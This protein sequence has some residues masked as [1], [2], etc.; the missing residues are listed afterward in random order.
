MRI[1]E[2]K[3][4]ETVLEFGEPLLGA[5]EAPTVEEYRR[6][7][8]IVIT[9]WNAHGISMANPHGRTVYLKE[10]S[11]YRKRAAADGAPPLFLAAFDALNARRVTDYADDPRCVGEW[12]LIPDGT[13][14]YKFRCDARLPGGKDQMPAR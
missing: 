2:R 5:L 8:E 3:I 9:V 6:G 14:G 13:G 4:S 10:L 12:D 11:R 1:P 7:L